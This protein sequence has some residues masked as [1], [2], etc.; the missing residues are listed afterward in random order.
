MLKGHRTQQMVHRF[1]LKNVGFALQALQVLTDSL[2]HIS[3]E[4]EGRHHVVPILAGVLKG[5]P[6]SRRY[7]AARLVCKMS[8]LFGAS[9]MVPSAEILVHW[10][11]HGG[12][13]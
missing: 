7:V 8:S 6:S 1:E 13:E 9:I 12:F 3:L 10:A 2:T 4:F 5:P 11:L